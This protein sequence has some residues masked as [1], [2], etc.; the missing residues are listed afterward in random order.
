MAQGNPLGSLLDRTAVVPGFGTIAYRAPVVGNTGPVLVLFHGIFAGASHR[1]F[2]E[3]L[4]LLDAAGARVYL[5]D[6]PGVG[7]SDSPRLVYD[8]GLLD[9]FVAAF[10]E[11][12][13][14]EPATVVMESLLGTSGLEVS[15]QRPDL[16]QRVVLLS[17]TGVVN[18]A[19][20]P[21]AA[22]TALFN[23]VYNN[24]VEGLL[25]YGA[26][27][28]TPSVRYFLSKAYY[29]QALITP[30]LVEQYQL[31]L[32]HPGQRWISFSFVGG[33]LYRRF[34]DVAPAVTVPVLAIFGANAESLGFGT[35]VETPAGFQKIRPDF[36]YLVLDQC[37]QEVQREQPAETAAAIL[38]FVQ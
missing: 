32:L 22:S 33:K 26:L 11:N 1:S 34:A 6:L 21:T 23:S 31:A 12:I 19:D 36:D 30:T 4:P 18:L 2:Y 25:F 16:V 15:V 27:L 35:P 8:I 5:M 29:N 9:Q 10:L 17:P 37:G 24:E 20:P 13:V 38:K 3:V 7:Q 28:S 14:Q